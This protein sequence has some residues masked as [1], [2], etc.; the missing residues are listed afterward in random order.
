M[1]TTKKIII[2]ILLILS[3]VV[4]P[5]VVRIILSVFNLTDSV[6]NIV[7]LILCGV[8]GFIWGV[9]IAKVFKFDEK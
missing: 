9:I 6:S 4:G 2:G 3:A 8:V 7:F 5:S 1:D